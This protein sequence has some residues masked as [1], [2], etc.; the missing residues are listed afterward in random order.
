MRGVPKAAGGEATS[1]VALIG[2]PAAAPKLTGD[3]VDERAELDRCCN[4]ARANSRGGGAFAPHSSL[5]AT[6]YKSISRAACLA[7]SLATMAL[8]RS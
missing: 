6:F 2:V 8:M 3:A 7:A 1:W 4:M 5:G